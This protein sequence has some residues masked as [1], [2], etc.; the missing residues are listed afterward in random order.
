[1]FIEILIAAFVG[2]CLGIITGLI[3]GIHVNLVATL[4]LS[5]APLILSHF[6]PIIPATIIIATALTHTFLDFIPSVFLGVPSEDNA[7][8]LLPA[9]RMVLEGKGYEAI[10]LSVIGSFFSVFSSLLVFFP[11]ILLINYSHKFIQNNLG[12]ILIIIVGILIIK[13]S[14]SKK[15]RYAFLMMLLSGALGYIVLN[16]EMLTNPLLP[17]LSGLFGTS[18]LISSLSQEASLP[19]QHITDHTSIKGKHT[20]RATGLGT[21]TSAITAFL[22]GVGAAQSASLATLATKDSST[23]EFLVLSGAINTVN[24]A[25]SLATFYVLDKA[26]NGAVVAVSELLQFNTL[27]L[28]IFLSLF[29]LL[30][31]AGTILALFIGSR[32]TTLMQKL[33]YKATVITIIILTVALTFYFDKFAGLLVLA[34]ST[35]LGLMAEEAGVAKNHMMGCL[36]IPV[37]LY[38]TI[39]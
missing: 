34:T 19:S 25:L 8:A 29:V 9:H 38:F 37:I 2:V 28:L 17:L 36:I 23:E 4:L 7:L 18:T 35:A 27:T 1:M 22:P 3:P 10:K 16:T 5:I 13:E 33:P 20:L 24:F 11:I 21:I 32:A 15:R 6:E 14:N 26:R 39:G 31:G 12:I 30:A